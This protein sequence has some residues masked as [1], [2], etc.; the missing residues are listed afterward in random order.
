M[1]QCDNPVSEQEK[2][3]LKPLALAIRRLI[4][5]GLLAGGIVPLAFAELPVPC[6]SCGAKG[7]TAWVSSGSATR[8]VRG[9]HLHINQRTPRAILNWQ[10]FNVGKNNGVQF[11]QPSRDAVALNRIYQHDPSRIHGSIKANGQVYLINQNGILFGKGAQV[12]TH[13]LVASTLN[14]SD[15][16]FNRGIT[17]TIAQG[18]GSVA[19][20][21]GGKMGGITI[22]EGAEIISAPQGRVM[23]LAPTIENRGTIET[24]DGQAILAAAKDRVY[25]KA[26]DDNPALRGLLVEVQTGGD[27]RNVGKIVAERGN[28]SLLGL[29]VNQDGVVRA[30]TSVR[31]NGSIRLMARDQA[32]VMNIDGDNVPVAS[33]TG[34]VTFGKDSVTEVLPDTTDTATAVDEQKQEPSRVDVMGK[35]VH[36]REG[37]RITAPG[38]QVTITATQDPLF[39]ALPSTPRNESSVVME[40]GSVIDV[41]GTTSTVLSA[42]RNLVSVELRT[43][44]L[45]DAPLQRDGAL[46]GQTIVVDRREGTPLTDISGAEANTQRTVNE[47]LSTGGTVTMRSEGDVILGKGSTVDFSGGQVAYAA[48]QIATT[49]LVSD[50]R[51]IDI[52]E[53]DPSRRYDGI[54]GV[55]TRQHRRWGVT[56]T[57][58][59]A[60]GL[61]EYSPAYVEGKDAGTFEVDAYGPVLNGTLLGHRTTGQF[62]RGPASALSEGTPAYAR[63][64]NQLP[65]GGQ[66]II[67]NA[68]QANVSGGN[69][70]TPDVHIG[71]AAGGPGSAPDA[72]SLGADTL[73]ASGVNRL[74]IYSNGRITLD[75]GVD[76]ALPGDGELHFVGGS[77]AIDGAITLPGGSVSLEARPTPDH[78]TGNTLTLGPTGRIDASGTWTNDS[79][80]LNTEPP[81]TPALPD[82]GSVS[83]FAAG[84]V[85]LNPGS[86]INVGGGGW[87]N[88]QGDLIAGRAGQI[89][90]ATRLL[91]G[92]ELF[93]NGGLSGYALEGGGSLSLEANSIHFGNEATHASGD[94]SLM[95]RFF[96]EGGFAAYSLTANRGSLTV[97]DE[98]LIAPRHENRLLDSGFQQRQTGEHIEDFSHIALLPEH[99]REP[100]DLT[101]TQAQQVVNPEPGVLTLG[102]GAWIRTEAGARVE[103]ASDHR[104]EVQGGIEAP[105]GEIALRLTNPSGGFDPG[106]LSSQAIWLGRDSQLLARAAP[107]LVPNTLG[108]RQGEVL[109]GGDIR[110]TADRGYVVTEAGSLMDVSGVSERLDLPG[111]SAGT[112]ASEEV[113]GNAGSIQITAAE[114]MLLDGDLR[115][116]PAGTTGASGGELH[117]SLNAGNRGDSGTQGFLNNPREIHVTTN[118]RDEVPD[119][120][121]PGDD[122]PAAFNGQARI[123]VSEIAGGGFDSLTLEAHNIVDFSNTLRS[124]AAIVFEGDTRLDLTRSIVLD[125]PAIDTGGHA[126]RLDAGYVALG[127]TDI[128][129]QAGAPATGGAG[130]LIASAGLIDLIGSARVRGADA[131]NLQSRGDLRLTGVQGRE[132]PG[133]IRGSF[134]AF[135]DLTLQ[136]DQVYPTTMSQFTLAVDSGS[137]G[138]LTIRPGSGGTPVLSAGGSLTME[139]PRIVQQGVVKAPLGELNFN[140]GDSLV[141]A[142]GSLTSTS[143][144]GQVIPFGR[145]EAGAD[146]VFPLTF[147][148]LVL[149]KPP[150]KRI[151]LEGD[152]VAARE[153]AVVDTSGGGDLLAYEFIP[154]PGG[155]RD[156]LAL[157]NAGNAFAIVPGFAGD[158]APFDPLESR[159]TAFRMGDSVYL[160][161]VDGLPAGVY[162]LLPA[163]YALLPGAFLVTPMAGY[164]DIL[165]DEPLFRL[166]GAPI[167]AGRFTAAGTDLMDSRTSGFAIEPQTVVRTRAEYTLTHAS[168]F[169]P[170]RA[171]A[172][173]QATPILPNDAGRLTIAAAQALDL[174]GTFLSTAAGQG[175][176]G[177]VDIEAERIAVVETRV[178]ETGTVQIE[179]RDLNRFEGASLLL[180][181]TRTDDEDGTHITTRSEAIRI[182]EGVRILAPEV[183]LTATDQVTVETG[184][185]ISAKGES[186]ATSRKLT[187]EGDGALLRVSA[188]EQVSVT[189]EGGDG[190]TGTL[191]LDKGSVLEADRSMTLDAS[192]DTR[193]NGDLR[194]RKGGSLNL[195][196]TH[197]RLG[198]TKGSGPGLWLSNE[199]LRTIGAAEL[200]L[201]S[202][203]AVELF[204]GLDLGLDHLVIDAAGLTGVN[205]EGKT[206]HITAGQLTLSHHASDA[207]SPIANAGNGRLHIDADEVI[208]GGGEYAIQGYNNVHIE[209][210]RSI[211]G[212]GKGELEVAGN[213]TLTST[214][215]TGRSGADLDIH[216]R[217]SVD[218]AAPDTLAQLA[219][220]GSLGAQLSITGREVFHHGRIELPA[221]TVD[222]RATAGDVVLG[223]GSRTDVTG[224]SL[225]FGDVSVTAPA[226]NISLV[227]EEGDVRMENGSLLDLSGAPQGGA[228]G[229]LTISA[230]KGETELAGTLRATA[231]KGFAGG[232]VDLDV[233]AL[234][235]LGA[236]SQ[237]LTAAGFTESQ[238]FRAR[239]GDLGIAAGE[240]AAAHAFHL[241]ADTGNVAIGGRIDAS[242]QAGGEVILS[243]RDG[244]TL[245]SGSSID[246]SASGKGKDGGRVELRTSQGTLDLQSG[247]GIDV[248]GGQD[249]EAGGVHL[250]APR[251]TTGVAVTALDSQIQGAGSVDLEAFQVYQSATIDAGLIATIQGDANNFMS[252]AATL[253]SA[254]GKGTDPRFHLL[255]GV[256]IQSTGDM[257]LAADWDLAAW[258]FDG[259]PGVLTLHAGGNLNINES[260]SDG[261]TPETNNSDR[262]MTGRSWSYRLVGGADAASADPLATIRGSGNLN[263][264]AATLIRTGAGDIDIAAGGDL[265]LNDSSSV[266][267]SAGRATSTNP[268]G[269]FPQ[270]LVAEGFP[271]QYSVDGGDISIRTGGDIQ[272]APVDQLMTDWLR[273][274]GDWDPDNTDHSGETPTAWGIAFE[275]FRQGIGAFGGGDVN[276]RAAGDVMNLSVV[277][278]TTGKQTG[279]LLS[280]SDPLYAENRVEILGGGDLSLRAEGDILGGLFAVGRGE[281]AIIAGGGIRAAGQDELG[282]ILSLGEGKMDLMA[283][284]GIRIE[285]VLNPTVLP[286]S[287]QEMESPDASGFYPYFFTYAD[288]SAVR[289][290]ALSGDVSLQNDPD[291]IAAQTNLADTNPDALAIPSL[292]VYPGWLEASALSGDILIDRSF[293]LFPS[294]QGGLRL[295]ADGD[296]TTGRNDATV[297]VNLSDTDP[298]LLPNPLR[299][300]ESYNEAFTRLVALGASDLIH[301]GEPLH[302][303]DPEPTRLVA[304]TGG[305]VPNDRLLLVSAEETR[306][307][308][309][310]DIRDIDLRVQHAQS[311]DMT[312]VEAGRDIAYADRRN[313]RGNIVGNQNRVQ[314][315][316]PGQL[317]VLAGRHIQLS[318]SE[319]I[320]T[321]GDQVNPALGDAGADVTIMAGLGKGPSYPAFIERYFVKS[322]AYR[323]ELTAYMRALTGDLDLTDA[324]ALKS[325]RE[326]PAFRQREMILKAFYHELMLA[327]QKG[328]KAGKKG[329]ARGF[330]AIRTLFPGGGWGGDINMVFSTI[331]TQDGGDI[332]M[333]VPGGEVNVGLAATLAN[334]KPPSELG[335]VVQGEGDISAFVRDDFMVNQ[336]RVFALDGGDIL[337][338]SSKGDIDAGRGA[339]TAIVA[340]PPIVTID[341]GGN[342]VVE[343]PP[344]VSGSG[345][346]GAVTSPGKQPGDVFLFAP[347]GVVNAG[348]AGIGSAGNLTVA[349]VAVIGTDNI[350]VGGASTGVPSV[351]TGGLAAGLTGVS[352]SASSATQSAGNPA[353]A[354]KD[355][356]SQNAMKE[357]LTFINVEVIGFGEGEDEEEE[358]K[359]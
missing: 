308:A 310:R 132:H 58:N 110:L 180:G 69:L 272:G 43:N 16:V 260:L 252:G 27:V 219:P 114:G 226:G 233:R 59:V 61:S 214:R 337:V 301:A 155:S 103:L 191:Q 137:D 2:P 305:I 72:L 223:A 221:G 204:G 268:Y 254:L 48:G 128:L 47:R 46:R 50:G 201:T 316:G 152:S 187:L 338:W 280:E 235:G 236:L 279:R 140:A 346:R 10:S 138:T 63:G 193:L 314:V 177:Q 186:P 208:L 179:A 261:F 278:P 175:R 100:T 216:A 98:T 287:R 213:L 32:S 257:T 334:S 28:V 88:G 276:I 71:N 245:A 147:T 89:R 26:S 18:E 325:F 1:T 13:S 141:L 282:T 29:A 215:I 134:T 82:G 255:P 303:S 240:T 120:M 218:I 203:N 6:G 195:G 331:R 270:S 24:P 283:N 79:P 104:L 247:S 271:A 319:G 121:K 249:G 73:A 309:G 65:L 352:N 92:S 264:A 7:P 237:R 119:G 318:A 115:G 75:K 242:G 143:A 196:A 340:P 91:G 358:K 81:A 292:T 330:A 183:L 39:P 172:R 90:I 297:Q 232:S 97:A 160:S 246:A 188:G 146:W 222:L 158:Y 136:A 198:E 122:I 85:D 359:D 173:D 311:D 194:L 131:I 170:A 31:A 329:F 265:V 178:P 322:N 349:A 234:A 199:D 277:L 350:Q 190:V 107:R 57:F 67:G 62:Q 262:L 165:P 76:L 111:N 182:G 355:K 317:H 149:D 84:D 274:I 320:K 181:G 225:P 328:G 354:L 144:E 229:R 117:L 20:V 248:S 157:E 17:Q 64:F 167:V 106:F 109:P 54:F 162:P 135:G 60:G 12:N 9:N 266:I 323:K 35:T 299:P 41:S 345:I 263:L 258:R 123:S 267:Y 300:Q 40:K 52:S 356:G 335:I 44:E 312:I 86:R 113:H 230:T 281:A 293:T 80:L 228:A 189:R 74:D 285:T 296:I 289:L 343:F 306:L 250:R 353:D 124:T 42:E 150:A 169:F 66:L 243:A 298:R 142:P 5:G 273:R 130:R 11:H 14:V 174:G 339:K 4:S 99:E 53:A 125:A 202:R 96:Q 102:H 163:R 321:I 126:I 227:S 327:G 139:A 238:G 30:T 168:D 295:F 341:G 211:A 93:L 259:E 36:L 244:V 239:E 118:D 45:R 51:I 3:C 253:E 23:I 56:E 154:G 231:A 15:A 342:M 313:E 332:R 112:Y 286:R 197:I 164:R 284:T 153:G 127:T 166:D 210:D 151:R 348:D 251:T 294:S 304:R 344:A 70:R 192:H 205:N 307:L 206:A 68:A 156:V 333:L 77:V 326:L 101:L 209:G 275:H 78:S 22:E 256:E 207:P 184:A 185:N 336:S 241:T 288:A 224:R 159:N 133:E 34:S 25:L 171:A 108:L 38:G 324:E 19:F 357:G 87:L 217:G 315:A 220:A 55:Y 94:L 148:N 105:A 33:R 8:A 116:R 129:S 269:S 161:G 351:Q 302:R 37:S 200:I 95:P 21:G 49:R 176:S 347:E 291:R 290:T 212:K 83:L 145:T